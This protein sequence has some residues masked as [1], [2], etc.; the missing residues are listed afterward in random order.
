M[1]FQTEINSVLV[2]C[3]ANYCRSPV[4][5]SILQM[6]CK[7]IDID[8]AGLIPFHKNSMDQRSKK[9]LKRNNVASDIHIPKVITENLVSTNNLILTMDFEVQTVLIKKF[10]KYSEKIYPFNFPDKRLLI[11]DP[12]LYS[13][14][15]E[16]EEV[17]SDINFLAS[18]WSELLNG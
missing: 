15:K 10:S 9:F 12:Y 1:Q 2:V 8:S 14:I 5:E 7:E 4:A 18:R 17:M 16:Y 13:T 3:K 11:R 6:N